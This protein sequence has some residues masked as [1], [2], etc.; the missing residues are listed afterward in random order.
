M[1][2][3]GSNKTPGSGRKKGSI[4]KR[5]LLIAEQ[6]EQSGKDPVQV[7]IDFLG[8]PNV[9][10]SFAAAKELLQYV[11]PKRKAIELTTQGYFR[12]AVKRLDGT[13]DEY[14]NEPESDNEE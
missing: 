9:S 6:I 12:R 1:R 13:I 8:H 14:T 11:H 4:N 3:K 7:M 5:T 2:P 10:L